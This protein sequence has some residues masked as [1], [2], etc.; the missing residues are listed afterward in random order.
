TGMFSYDYKTSDNKFFKKQYSQYTY[1]ESTDAYNPVIKHSPTTLKR[2]YYS[3]PNT[4]SEISLKYNHVFSDI[5]SVN[6]LLLLEHSVYNS[7]NFYASRQLSLPIDQ[8]LA[9]NSQNQIG[10]MYSNAL[11]K[12]ASRGLVGRF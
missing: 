9:G 11:F 6:A 8:L 10:N 4:L 7:D 1:D 2:E 5:H 3:K 12:N